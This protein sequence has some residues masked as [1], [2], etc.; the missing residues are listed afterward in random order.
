VVMCGDTAWR[1]LTGAEVDP[2]EITNQGPVELTDPIST[3]RGII[4]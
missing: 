2:F 1:S 4:V 3:V